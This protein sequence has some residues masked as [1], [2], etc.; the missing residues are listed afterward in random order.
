MKKSV[1]FGTS[2]ISLVLFVSG[3]ASNKKPAPTSDK[4]LTP[5]E[6]I[7]RGQYEK[8]IEIFNASDVNAVDSAGNT[9]LHVA[10][11]VN[12]TDM[13]SYLLLLGAKTKIKNR[14]G[15]T[16]LHIAINNNSFESAKLLSE[17]G[18]DIFDKDSSGKTALELASAKG[19]KWYDVAITEHTGSVVD[20][21]GDSI[22]HYFVRNLDEGAVN[23]AIQKKLP[24][25][26]KNKSGKIP[27]FYG[28]ERP[29]NSASVR[30]GASLVLAGSELMKNELSY[31][32]DGLR[33]HNMLMRFNDGQTPLHIAAI[34]GHTGV[35]DY[36]V[37]QK[38][39]LKMSDILGAQ[40]IS[41]ATPL[42]E[43]VRYGQLDSVNIL[44][45]NGANVN[46][47]D[48]IGKTPVLLIISGD[49]QYK[50]Y[51]TLV[52]H[53][54][55]VTHKDMYGDTV[56]HV[57]T[58]A[59]VSE[60][61]LALLKNAGALVNERNKQGVTPLSLAVEN[62]NKPHVL[63]YMRNK[64]DIHAEDMDGNSPLT[65]AL[66]D[67]S[68]D[69]LK[70]LVTKDNVLQAD[71]QGNTP[72]HVAIKRDAQLDYIKY[73]VSVGADVN[74]RN[75][76]GDSV[77]YLTVLKNRKAA[78]ELFISKGADIFATN[79]QNNS[80]LR[81]AF[82]KGERTLDWFISSK[83]LNATDGTLNTPLHYAAEW[84]LNDSVK[85]LISKNAKISP[86]NANGETPV[87][88]AV[89]ANAPEIILTLVEKGAAIDSK[90]PNAR[91]NQGNTPLHTAVHW[92]A[93]E[94]AATLISL[95]IDVDSQNLSGKSA[96]SD[97]CRMGKKN[98]AIL[99][100]DNG[101][102]INLADPVG[103]TVLMDAIAGQNE[104]LVKLLLDKG[105]D[106][107]VQEMYGRNA[108]HEA[109]ETQ[110]IGIINMIRKAGGKALDRDS[111]GNTPLSIAFGSD[112]KVISAVLGN[113]ISIVDS[114]GNTPIHV[115]V[116]NKV[117]STVLTSLLKKGYPFSTRNA[118]GVTPLNIAVSQDSRALALTLLEFGADPYLE[119][120]DGE[121]PV[122]IVFK[123]KNM[124]ILD[125][126]VK[127]N[128]KK[129]DRQGDGILHYAA[130]TAD[131]ET[132][133]HLISLGTLD[134]NKKNISGE[135]AAQMAARWDR[136]Q[137]ADLLK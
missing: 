64:A 79:T 42:H 39:S 85:Y 120:N 16:A 109:A 29:E 15:D 114:D 122:T 112:E 52:K 75:H 134:K 49:S 105:A 137:I 27:L 50:I 37:H 98:I 125:S 57:G 136:P 31:F 76:N 2:L 55:D 67:P 9:C 22:L 110:N 135:T 73:L 45:D 95:G 128:A 103:R 59:N 23:N 41:G 123:T 36:I 91:D 78:G 7:V 89:K 6:L 69:M 127:F 124:Q 115:A 99:L 62:H 38:T 24:L 11:E 87:F 47:P 81:V 111:A 93:Y 104:D 33:K 28:W 88:S 46:A 129:S 12:S 70:L 48:S 1:I 25:S 101:A 61:I 8:A 17:V 4:T 3:C 83:T 71:T 121:N 116:E 54:A 94:A 65:K 84:R 96:L 10:A 86:K 82:T 44:L 108:Y 26:V 131:E 19:G 106:V 118:Q 133:K 113:D 90:N 102:D 66:A 74:A 56:F 5:Q 97:A 119:T 30:I 34:Q 126:I 40:D 72:L 92:N 13:V 130:R 100:M 107:T 35:V 132:V 32:E 80:P 51:E 43:A 20:D 77:L 60:E 68:I 117:S 58:M 18:D 21:N 14:S 53:G 63:F